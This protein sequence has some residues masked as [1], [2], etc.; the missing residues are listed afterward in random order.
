MVHLG[1]SMICGMWY[2]VIHY[3]TP[4]QFLFFLIIHLDGTTR[5]IK[6]IYAALIE[7]STNNFQV[8]KSGNKHD[9]L[10]ISLLTFESREVKYFNKG[11]ESLTS[12]KQ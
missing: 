8:S 4:W 10:L 2:V 12:R 1:I 11:K 6:E 3:W 7:K 5:N 9:F